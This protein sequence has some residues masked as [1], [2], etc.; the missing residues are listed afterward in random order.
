M[1]LF[2]VCSQLLPIISSVFCVFTL[3]I[4]QTTTNLMVEWR[5]FI[6]YLGST[7]SETVYEEGKRSGKISCVLHHHD[8][9]DHNAAMRIRLVLVM[10]LPAPSKICRSH[11]LLIILVR[12]L[13]VVNCFCEFLRSSAYYGTIIVLCATA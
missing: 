12:C 5:C 2:V 10:L 8:D 3:M 9:H 13:C 1:L 4:N 11:I 6:L 7:I